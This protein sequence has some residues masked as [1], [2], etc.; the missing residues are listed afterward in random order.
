MPATTVMRLS[1]CVVYENT[2][3][4]QSCSSVHL[5]RGTFCD[6][7][8]YLFIQG[9]KSLGLWGPCTGSSLEIPTQTSQVT[10]S[11]AG[12]CLFLVSVFWRTKWATLGRDYKKDYQRANFE[13]DED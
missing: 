6:S 3:G 7:P 12:K 4:L 8:L 2:L 1:S 9:G 13:G 10:F 5:G 11:E